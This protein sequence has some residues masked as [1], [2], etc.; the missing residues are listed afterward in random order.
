MHDAALMRIRFDTDYIHDARGRMVRS[1]SPDALPAPRLL[2][3]RTATGNV[4]RFGHHLPDAVAERLAAIIARE[5][6]VTNPR[7][8]LSCLAP[9]RAELA[10]HAPIEREG[11]G[12]V[13]RFPETLPPAPGA[14]LVSATAHAEAARDTFPWVLEPGWQPCFAVVRDGVAVSVCCTSRLGQQAAEAGVQTL[15]AF[16]GHGY[17]TSVTAAWG[18]AI[19]RHGRTPIYSTAWD[20]HASQGVARRLGLIMFGADMYLA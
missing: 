20:N 6:V 15:P 1:N 8:P 17:A 14:V 7:A 16:R 12:P 19:R 10:A 9:L 5:P 18:A 3:G 4:Y 13:Y 11:G 2:L